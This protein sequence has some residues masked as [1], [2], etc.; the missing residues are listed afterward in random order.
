MEE[1]QKE[2][3]LDEDFIDDSRSDMA[4]DESG[5]SYSSGSGSD[6]YD[7]QSGNSSH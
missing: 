2:R 7:E 3:E 6:Y 4:S 1:L 5:S